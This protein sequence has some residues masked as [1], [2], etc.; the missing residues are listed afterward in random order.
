MTLTANEIFPDEVTS[1]VYAH[2][3]VIRSLDDGGVQYVANQ[4]IPSEG[5]YGQTWN[6]SD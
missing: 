2:E 1:K 6:A 5:N 3:V 4:I